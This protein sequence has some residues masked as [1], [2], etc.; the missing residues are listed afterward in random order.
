MSIQ[1]QKPSLYLFLTEGIRGVWDRVKSW[2]FRHNHKRLKRGDGHPVF[3]IPGL[4]SND[5]AT[6]PLRTLLDRLGYAVYGWGLGINL[7]DLDDVIALDSKLKQ[8]YQT[9]Q[10]PVT[11]IGWSLGGLYTRKIARD[12]IDII[13]QII[14]LG[15]P[16]RS[17]D[18]QGAA[19]TTLKILYRSNEIPIPPEH[20]PWISK[21]KDPLELQ[22]SSVYSKKD[23]IVPWPLCLESIEDHLH[24]NIEISSSHTG[25]V[26][27]LGAI[28]VILRKLQ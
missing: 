26:S 18:V 20:Q 2:R 7:A 21:I 13:R 10:R 23:G 12:N 14:T 27:N 8:I 1:A 25:M 4:L 24:E 19:M 6:K 22:T 9:H 3:V 15:S 16:F 28:K 17:L 5:L 11:I